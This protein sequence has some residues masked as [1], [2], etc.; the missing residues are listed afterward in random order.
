[1]G[2]LA[3]NSDHHHGFPPISKCNNENRSEQSVAADLDGTLLISKSA[4]PYFMLV[5]VEAGSLLRGLLLLLSIPFVYFSYIFISET[6]AIKTFIFITFAGLN[7]KDIEIVARSV[8]PRFYAEDVHPETWKVFSSFG[9]RYIVTAN[10]R[11]LVEPFVKNFLGVDKVFGTELQV[12]CNSGRASGFVQ[13]PGVLVG[14]HKKEALEREF[15]D[16]L[17]DLGLGDRKSDQAFMSVCKEGY[18]VPKTKCEP[19]QRNKLLSRVIFHEGRLVQRPTPIS[20]LLTFLWLPIGFILALLRIYISIFLPERI[21]WYTCKFLRVKIT[22]KGNPPSAPRKGQPGVLLVC[23]HR[24]TLDP[25]I[26]AVALGRKISC[27]TYSISKFSELISPIKTVALTREREKDA[28]NIKRLLEEGDLMICPEGTTCR[29]PFLLRFSALFAEL[30]DR[31]VP[32]AIHTKQSVFFGTSTRGFKLMDPYFVLM[33]PVP[34]YE[35]TFLNQLPTEMTCKGGK[36]PV[37]VANY[38]QRLLART[39]AFECTNLTRKDKYEM[40]AGTDGIVRSKKEKS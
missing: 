3:H 5:A 26:T 23:N 16:N 24:T 34:T 27:V 8:L 21:V 22:V 7:I 28:A 2:A 15:R 20:A 25:V 36:S 14:V 11:I 12:L 39:L 17:P 9:K 18:M 6:L 33:N 10:L 30:T 1:M 31:I 4:F 32:V 37:E 19:V 13:K 38:I 35:I 29:E 40:L